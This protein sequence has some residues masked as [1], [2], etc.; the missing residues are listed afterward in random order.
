MLL[1]P[2][3][4]Q[5]N[6]HKHE[7]LVS[8]SYGDMQRLISFLKPPPHRKQIIVASLSWIL[9]RWYGDST[10]S[11]ITGYY[12]SLTYRSFLHPPPSHSIYNS[13]LLQNWSPLSFS[14]P[15]SI[16]LCSSV[17]PPYWWVSNSSLSLSRT[18]HLITFAPVGE[19]GERVREGGGVKTSVA[20]KL[21]LNL[22]F[23]CLYLH[24]DGGE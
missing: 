10:F 16:I 5:S 11:S 15:P 7:L 3:V 12:S 14:L 22:R 1:Y 9:K 20:I 2:P 23:L 21:G 4:P 17:P 18:P 6:K 24:K 8:L 19:G 13:Y